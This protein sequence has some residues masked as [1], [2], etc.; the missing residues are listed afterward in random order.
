MI[1]FQLKAGNV[2]ASAYISEHCTSY[3]LNAEIGFLTGLKK[4][5]FSDDVTFTRF[6]LI[7]YSLSSSFYYTDHRQ[8]KQLSRPTRR[9]YAKK[10][11]LSFENFETSSTQLS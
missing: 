1:T 6:Q 11:S 4:Q 8:H 5:F 10:L 7:D 2:D 3:C 9:F